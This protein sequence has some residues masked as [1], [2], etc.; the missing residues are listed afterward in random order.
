MAIYN[1]TQ[2]FEAKEYLLTLFD[3][4]KRVEIKPAPE[5]KSLSQNSYIWLVFTHIAYETGNDKNDI[6]YYFLDRFPKYKEITINGQIEHV[7]ISLSSFTKE[8]TR[9]FIDEVVI[10]ANTEGFNVPNPEDIK[11]M[12]MYEFYRNKGLI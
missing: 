1:P 2:R 5:K 8:Q 10:Y 3:S 7:S 11:I 12:Q 9:A 4:G 6:Y